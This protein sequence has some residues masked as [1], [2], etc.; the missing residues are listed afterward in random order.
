M[1][2]VNPDGSISNTAVHNSVYGFPSGELLFTHDGQIRYVGGARK[3]WI[4][5]DL[6]VFDPLTGEILLPQPIDFYM[7]VRNGRVIRFRDGEYDIDTW[8]I[9]YQYPEGFTGEVI[10]DPNYQYALVEGKGLLDAQTGEKLM[11]LPVQQSYFTL[12]G[13]F[14]VTSI[15]RRR[16]TIYRLSE[17][18]RP[19]MP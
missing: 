10:T 9:A 18:I 12:D 15:N 5:H 17:H 3:V 8:E 4:D 19:L 14:L 11:R 6:G 7:P 2:L 1:S 13:Q 16:C